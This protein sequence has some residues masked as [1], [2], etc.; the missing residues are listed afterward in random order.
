MLSLGKLDKAN[1]EYEEFKW[2]FEE[3]NDEL[4]NL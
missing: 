3:R 1:I 4:A 2:K